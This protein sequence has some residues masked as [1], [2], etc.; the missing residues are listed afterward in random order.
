MSRHR[1]K[2]RVVFQKG[3]KTWT[4]YFK[5]KASAKRA[6]AGLEKKSKW[7]TTSFLKYER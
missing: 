1:N 4:K 5:S 2:I 7:H 6:I 3:K